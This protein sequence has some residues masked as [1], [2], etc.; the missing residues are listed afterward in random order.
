MELFGT[1]SNPQKSPGESASSWQ[2]KSWCIKCSFHMKD[3]DGY[4]WIDVG[5][6]LGDV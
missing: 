3:M 4:G 2:H 5:R 6:D 1:L